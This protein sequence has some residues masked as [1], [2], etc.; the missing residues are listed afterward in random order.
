MT[1]ILIFNNMIALILLPVG[2]VSSL[3]NGLRGSA[4]QR[5]VPSTVRIILEKEVIPKLGLKECFERACTFMRSRFADVEQA[6]S[7]SLYGLFKQ[8]QE[9]SC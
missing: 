7:L 3:I 2:L 9:G 6:T 4:P 5:R 1:E 8:A